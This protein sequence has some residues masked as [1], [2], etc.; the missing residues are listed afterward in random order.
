[1]KGAFTGAVYPKKGLFE[2]AD[3]GTIFFDEIGNIPLDTQAKLL[4]V[5]QEREFMRLG[6]VETIKVDVRII[7][8]TN[9]N[10]RDMMKADRFREDLFYRLNVIIVQLPPLRER[11]DDIPLLVQHFLDKFVEESRKPGH[12]R[13]RPTRWIG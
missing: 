2:L 9:V 12:D 5:I 3:K 13:S 11:K 8:A 6:G 4:R 1:M 7:A 10:L